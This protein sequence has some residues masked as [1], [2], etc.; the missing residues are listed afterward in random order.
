M[1]SSVIFRTNRDD[2]IVIC[3]YGLPFALYVSTDASYDCHLDSKSHTGVSF[4]LGRFSGSF[5]SLS[6]KQKITADSSTVPE[7]RA[8]TSC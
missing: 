6:K 4:H 8:H 2:G 3:T 5:M 1:S 7:F